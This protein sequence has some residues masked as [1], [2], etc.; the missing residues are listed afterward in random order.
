MPSIPETL[1]LAVAHHNGGRL[2]DAEALYRAILEVEPRHADSLHLL[3]LIA[4]QHERYAAALPLISQAIALNG[5]QPLYQQHLGMTLHALKRFDEAAAAFALALAATP[6][7]SDLLNNLGNLYQDWGRMDEALDCR[8]RALALAPDNPLVHFNYGVTLEK[9]GR[10]EEATEMHRA[11]LR[12]N[13]EFPECLNGL[14]EIYRKSGKLDDAI[15]HYQR[16]LALRPDYA[17]ALNNLGVAYKT[18]GLIYEAA[19]VL[20]R[21]LTVAPN[22]DAALSNLAGV[23]QLQGRIDE[24]VERYRQAV[25]LNPDQAVIHSNLIFALTHLHDTTG[26]TLLD[27]AKRWDRH[28][29]RLIPG[30]SEAFANPPDPERR[31]RIGFVSPDFRDHAVSYFLL[32]LFRNF[33]RSAFFVA[34]YNESLSEDIVTGWFRERVDCWRDSRA[35]HDAGLADMIRADA[36]DILIDCSGHS[37]GGR[38]PVFKRRPAPVQVS[39]PLGHGGTTG[40]AEMDYFLSDV[41][42]T[43]E[44]HESQFSETLIRL[45]RVF[46]PFEPKDFWPEPEGAVPGELLFGCFGDPIRISSETLELWKRLLDAAPG[47]RILFKNKAYTQP[48]MEQHWRSRFAAL[49]DRALFEGLPGGWAKNMDVYRRVRV[50]LDT[51]PSTG[52]TSSLIPLWMGVPVLTRAGSHALQR[53]GVSILNNAGLPDLVAATDAAYV[54]AGARLIADTERL[55]RLRAELRPRLCASAL[56]DAAGVTREWEAALRRIWRRWCEEQKT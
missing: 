27:E 20:Q 14:G 23:L 54:A 17:L 45:D 52:A 28:Q 51:F 10:I 24:A 41:H 8:R 44:G 4:Y 33:D 1:Q 3:G 49:A 2:A 38:L 30:T 19:A 37:G 26:A 5:P 12:L 47:A 46:A 56:C 53:F 50:M 11:A 39:T 13:P 6:D 48:A 43:P 31:L 40:V 35:I 15:A 36:I 32:P 7:N 22:H 16:T 25:K 18:Q 34:C 42:L 29:S 9:L 55:K 21:C